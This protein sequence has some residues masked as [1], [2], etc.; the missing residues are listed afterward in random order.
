MSQTA[1]SAHPAQDSA[2]GQVRALFVHA[3]PDDESITTGG[4]MAE[5]VN[6]GAHVTLLTASRG[7]GGE[8]IG[9]EFAHLEGDR[10]GLAAHREQELAAAMRVLGVSDHRFLTRGDTAAGFEDSGM[11][12]GADGHAQAPT[13]MP[14]AALCNT[15]LPDVA[16]QIAR[17]IVEVRP[18]LVI[19][20]ASDGGYGHPDHRYVHEA[21]V[22]AVESLSP[23]IEPTLLF[24]ETPEGTVRAAIDPSQPGF[25]LTGFDAADA[26]TQYAAQAPVA[27][28][29]DVRDVIGRKSLAMASH[30]TQITVAGE[31]YALS[32]NL[33]QAVGTT[34]FYS[35]A[36]YPGPDPMPGAPFASV[37]DVAAPDAA[38]IGPLPEQAEPA[39]TPAGA[40]PAATAAS[41]PAVGA[42]AAGSATVPTAA[43]SS[44]TASP[45][46]ASASSETGA[47]DTAQRPGQA[48]SDAQAAGLAPRRLGPAAFF[49]ALVLGVLVAVLGTL[50]HLNASVVTLGGTQVIVP[51]GVVLALVLA[52]GA[53]WHV[54]AIYRSTIL[55][56]VL[57]LIISLGAFTLG[58]PQLLPGH[59]LLVV[60]TLRSLAWLFGPMILA[61]VF[62]FTLPQLKKRPV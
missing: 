4:T 58:Q 8:V 17:V 12:W 18:H 46:P 6:A 47:D 10:P 48:D 22:A 28:A 3:H 57:A 26:P 5:L 1:Q 43:A 40:S 51:W 24:I 42:T 54:S 38:V 11:E 45:P 34:E 25:D 49:H 52:A 36:K 35:N 27:V 31:F 41:S 20:Y 15:P 14:E 30:A 32:N 16:E 9:E 39:L 61:A 13:T 29:Q 53:M 50:Q 37:L 2:R 55:M 21:T 59:D 60:S 62:A 33:G 19:T 23:A 44:S 56:V 7:E